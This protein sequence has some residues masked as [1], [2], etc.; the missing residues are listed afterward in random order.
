MRTNAPKLNGPGLKS[1]SNVKRATIGIAY[2]TYSAMT[3]MEKTALI[4]L[5]TRKREQTQCD[6]EG[7]AEPDRVNWRLRV[8]VHAV[9]DVGEREGPIASESKRLSR[10]GRGAWRFPSCTCGGHI[11]A[12]SCKR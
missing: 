10:G 11:R 12:R 7:S 8:R 4:A 5:S 2:A 9:Q 3:E 1:L 6:G